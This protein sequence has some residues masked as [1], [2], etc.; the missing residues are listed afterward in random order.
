MIGYGTQIL[1]SK[2]KIPI[3]GDKVFYSGHEGKPIVIKNDV[4]IGANC[5]ILAGVTIGQGAIVASG[6]VVTK[7]VR[8]YTVV[9]GVPAKLIR[10]RKE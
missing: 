1:S 3:D 5:I 10:N 4:W 2:H 7:D 9:G 6:S 8:A